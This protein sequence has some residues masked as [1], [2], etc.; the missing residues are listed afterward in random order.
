[1]EAS[2]KIREA[3]PADVPALSALHVS[4]F[5]ETHGRFGAPTINTRTAQWQKLFD[6]NDGTWFCFVIEKPG[7]GL[8]GF[9]KG[10]PHNEAG[11]EYSGELNK[12]YILRKFHKMGLG[13]QLLCKVANEFIRR[14]INSMLLFGDAKNKSNKFY[15]RMGAQKLLAK[16]GEFHG[17]YGWRDL[18][19]LA[20]ACKEF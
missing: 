5:K 8:I 9:A 16:N 19:K 20:D 2:F 10:Q 12:I 4:T 1:V 14:G 15:E 18:Q 7:E 11:S 13:R 3:T 6:N 17:G